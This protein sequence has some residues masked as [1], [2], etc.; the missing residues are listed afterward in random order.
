LPVY[1][2]ERREAPHHHH[3]VDL[4]KQ[5][6]IWKKLSKSQKALLKRLDYGLIWAR[7]PVTSMQRYSKEHL[8]PDALRWIA[9]AD[10]EILS[11]AKQRDLARWKECTRFVNELQKAGVSWLSS[12]DGVEDANASVLCQKINGAIDSISIKLQASHE[13]SRPLAESTSR[14]LQKLNERP[15]SHRQE[16]DAHIRRLWVICQMNVPPYMQA[17]KESEMFN[18]QWPIEE[19]YQDLIAKQQFGYI[20]MHKFEEF[21][22]LL[23]EQKQLET[24]EKVDVQMDP[25][26][27][28]FNVGKA[29]HYPRLESK[30]SDAFEQ[31]HEHIQ[32]LEQSRLA[33]QQLVDFGS[34]HDSKEESHAKDDVLSVCDLIEGILSKHT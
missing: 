32:H 24:G 11:E 9:F 33:L 34:L 19:T 16:V 17:W 29:V 31:V 4:A 5:A 15:S 6:C 1:V 3:L 23:A 8:I 21:E 30:L 12:F 25:N 10:L 7:Y 2:K 18:A 22:R 26:L 28:K 20:Q 27:K 14:L 13:G